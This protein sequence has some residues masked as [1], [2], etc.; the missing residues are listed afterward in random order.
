MTYDPC[1]PVQW[2]I[3]WFFV[4]FYK[5]ASAVNLPAHATG[6]PGKQAVGSKFV[7]AAQHNHGSIWGGNGGASS[8]SITYAATAATIITTAPVRVSQGSLI[9]PYW[10]RLRHQQRS[11]HN[12][13]EVWTHLSYC[14]G[15]KAVAIKER[16][17]L[18]RQEDYG[19]VLDIQRR[20]LLPHYYRHFLPPRW[21]TLLE[22]RTESTA[23]TAA[24]GRRP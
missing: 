23:A 10:D 5:T 3:D 15:R 20:L 2:L 4:K 1:H 17:L 19:W 9:A 22:M 21:R 7:D 11:P 14:D 13:I 18:R 6:I 16:R 8:T 12:I 24:A